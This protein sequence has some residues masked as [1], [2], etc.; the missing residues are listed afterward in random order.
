MARLMSA[1]DRLADVLVERQRRELVHN[2]LDRTWQASRRVN[3][4]NLARLVE[5]ATEGGIQPIVAGASTLQFKAED[6]LAA[7]KAIR[8]AFDETARAAEGS[9]AMN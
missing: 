2:D 6:M 8:T 5:V 3:L 9:Q 1:T 7:L 4:S